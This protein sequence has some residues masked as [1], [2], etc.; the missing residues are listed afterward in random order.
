MLSRPSPINPNIP[1]DPKPADRIILLDAKETKKVEDQLN[2]RISN[3]YS[4]N[5]YAVNQRGSRNK[6]DAEKELV[7]AVN[8][9]EKVLQPDPVKVDDIAVPQFQ[10]SHRIPE[11]I[12]K[13]RNNK[14]ET[15]HHPPTH[16]QPSEQEMLN[17]RPNKGDNHQHGDDTSNIHSEGHRH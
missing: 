4:T 7:A 6:R 12:Q 15:S 9:T 3:G 13:I 8:I 11:H 16:I 2:R 14:F 10:T 17:S 5:K 1:S